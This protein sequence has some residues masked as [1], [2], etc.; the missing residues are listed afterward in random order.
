MRCIAIITSFFLF[1]LSS[2]TAYERNPH[3]DPQVWDFLSPFFLPEDEPVK[4]K[5]DQL[6]SNTRATL[7]K[8]ALL[9]A[10]FIIPKRG[11]RA[12]IHATI[13]KHP[14]MKRYIFKLFTDD[15]DIED[16]PNMARRIQGAECIREAIK[17]FG[18]ESMF[19]V[20]KKWIYPLPVDP[21][22]PEGS[23]RKNFILVAQ[24]MKLL[25]KK[26]NGTAW[27]SAAINPRVL[28]ALYVLLQETGLA[29]SLIASNIPFSK[30]DAR[31][32]FVDT[33][34]Y[35]RWPIPFDKLTSFLSPRMQ[36]YWQELINK[37]GPERQLEK[38]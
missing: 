21:S 38:E 8:E 16:W 31:I 33:E 35:H 20:P 18:Y 10:G 25:R 29:D 4:A 13:L 24:N 2:A 19:S 6:F 23:Y 9:E 36:R 7:N 5:L 27:Q 37:G 34:V 22:P 12:S 32:S 3:V 17:K 30:I 26:A 14:K 15:Q 1:F 11:P 28:D